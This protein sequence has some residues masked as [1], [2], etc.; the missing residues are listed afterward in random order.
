[1][2]S[3]AGVLTVMAKGDVSALAAFDVN[4]GDLVMLGAMVIWALYTALLDK[5]PAMHVLTFA[6]VTYTIASLLN[7][8]LAAN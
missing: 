7:A 4:R 2:V 1:M 3:L 6:A 5:R 8:G